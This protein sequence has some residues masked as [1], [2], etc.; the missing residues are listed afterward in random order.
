MTIWTPSALTPDRPLYLAIADAL[1]ADIHGRVLREGDRLPPHR[2]LADVLGVTVGTVTRAYL[3]A[4]R[5]GLIRGEV[6]RGTFVARRPAESVTLS[7][8]SIQPKDHIDLGCSYPVYDQDPDLA[9]AV[10]RLAG[11]SGLQE[12]LRYQPAEGALR[13]RIAGASWIGRLGLDVSPDEVVITGGAQHAN[14]IIFAMLAEPGDVILTEALTFPNIKA[15]AAMMHLRLEPVEIDENGLIPEAF[16]AACRRSRARILYCIPTIHNPTTAVLS[17]DRRRRIAD[18]ARTYDVMI[19]EDENYRLLQPDAPP[20][21]SAFAREQCFLVAS[22]SKSLAAGLRIAYVVG[23]RAH[24]RRLAHSVSATMLMAPPLAAEIA[25][26]WMEDGTAERVVREKRLESELRQRL[27][28]DYLGSF[29]YRSQPA[30]YHVWLE[31]PAP[32]R[33]N[34][35]ATEVYR[36]GVSVTP[37]DAFVVGHAA[38]PNAVRISPSAAGSR[39]V[40]ERALHIIADTLR[41]PPTYGTCL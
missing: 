20:L 2:E 7:V 23:P 6:G 15:L 30:S 26:M 11:R 33:V 28:R 4:H 3:E 36:R 13:H 24:H 14:M 16:E 27:V 35:F 40:L 29:R 8:P 18:I 21:I 25:A 9:Q 22:L 39:D 1:A 32:W 19:V 31:L 37:A 38:V 10:G 5:R 34:E 12:M 17:E 41:E